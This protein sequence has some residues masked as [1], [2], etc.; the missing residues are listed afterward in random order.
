M[1]IPIVFSSAL[2]LAFA[3]APGQERS[4]P[5]KPASFADA[6]EAAKKH[7]EADKL[8]A[9]IA[10]LQAAIVDLQKKQRTA[11]LAALPKPEGWTIEDQPV[12][13]G[14]DAWT[15]GLAGMGSTVTRRYSRG[16][17]SI[18]VEVTANSPVVG[19]MSALFNSPA[20]IEADGGEI[21]KY[22]AHRAILKKPGDNRQELQLLMHDAH[23]V[24][25]DATGLDAD[26]LLKVFDQAF[27]DRLEKPLGR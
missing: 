19:M 14:N 2:L 10:S 7:V 27:V 22:G 18:Q 13:E 26:A 20:L 3:V 9:A 6:V 12:N 23:L 15:P 25:V 17:D 21:V 16:D 8:G 11:V 5:K 24:K 4:G 1:R